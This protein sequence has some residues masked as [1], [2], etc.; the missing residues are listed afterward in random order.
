MSYLGP[1]YHDADGRELCS[2]DEV[3][4][5]NPNINWVWKD[6]WLEGHRVPLTGDEL[7]RTQNAIFAVSN[8]KPSEIALYAYSLYRDR[9][10]DEDGL[11]R[12]AEVLFCD[13]EDFLPD[14]FYGR[15]LNILDEYLCDQGVISER[16][17]R[18]LWS[19]RHG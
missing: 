16:D 1:F 18:D 11:G 5:L 19:E 9:F 17:V 12:L 6:S 4:A 15:K 3:L 2:Y 10:I 8:F 13:F 14:E 7:R